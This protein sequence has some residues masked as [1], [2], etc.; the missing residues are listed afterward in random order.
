MSDR[1]VNLILIFIIGNAA[2]HMITI[3][4]IFKNKL[5]FA[6]EIILRSGVQITVFLLSIMVLMGWIIG[7]TNIILIFD[8]IQCY[9]LLVSLLILIPIL[10]VADIYKSNNDFRADDELKTINRFFDI[11]LFFLYGVII[12]IAFFY[13]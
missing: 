7:V 4:I 6:I 3:I 8:D 12:I 5:D 1:F 10:L 13:I 9:I 11:S 2:E